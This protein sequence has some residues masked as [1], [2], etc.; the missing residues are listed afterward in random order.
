MFK[1]S[2]T[3]IEKQTNIILGQV[4]KCLLKSKTAAKNSYSQLRKAIND[5][6]LKV[7]KSAVLEMTSNR[8]LVKTSR[9]PKMESSATIV[10]G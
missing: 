10:N 8:N 9:Q 3:K 2:I 1:G 6:N 5:L 7:L 4:T